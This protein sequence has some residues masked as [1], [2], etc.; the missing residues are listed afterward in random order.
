MADG[1][2]IDRDYTAVSNQYGKLDKASSEVWIEFEPRNND[3][4]NVL[5]ETLPYL[6][7]YPDRPTTEVKMIRC[8][9]DFVM[10]IRS[11]QN[12]LI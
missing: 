4:Y 6:D 7:L 12:G 5:K 8:L 2:F 3:T 11:S 1:N 9:S 10:T